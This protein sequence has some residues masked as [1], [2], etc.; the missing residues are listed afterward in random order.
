MQNDAHAAGLHRP[1]N[2]PEN[3]TSAR[4]FNSVIVVTYDI[5]LLRCP[6]GEIRKELERRN[7]LFLQDPTP[8]PP[9]SDELTTAWR[10]LVPH[11][12]VELGEPAENDAYRDHY[13]LAWDHPRIRLWFHGENATISVPYWY[14]GEEAAEALRRAFLLGR[15]LQELTGFDAIDHQTGL[16]IGESSLATAIQEYRSTHA[17]AQRTIF[18]QPTPTDDGSEQHP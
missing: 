3:G 16:G 1:C 2:A 11:L 12:V 14:E 10:A 18:V 13:E 8:E 9:I 5:T 4:S 7:R 15:L 6:P 17:A